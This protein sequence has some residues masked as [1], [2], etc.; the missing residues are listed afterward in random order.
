MCRG[1]DVTSGSFSAVSAAGLVASL[2]FRGG[3]CSIP[4]AFL[5]AGDNPIVKGAGR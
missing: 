3:E 2:V 4:A 5:G 1:R